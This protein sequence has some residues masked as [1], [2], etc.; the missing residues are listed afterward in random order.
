M[1]DFFSAIFGRTPDS[2]ARS[3]SGIPQ[4]DDTGVA[5]R[6]RA[7]LAAD[8]QRG[9]TT[10]SMHMRTL[11]D[12]CRGRDVDAAI[13]CMRRFAD[14]FRQIGLT[15]SVHLYPY[16]RWALER[17]HTA[18]IQ[19][20]SIYRDMERSTLLI[21][22]ILTDYLNSPWERDRRRR[23]VHVVVRVAG[24]FGHAVRLE[25]SVLLPLYLPPGQ[26]RYVTSTAA[27]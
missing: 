25:T 5:V 14:E 27:S 11:L 19:F 21:E 12:A 2:S 16:L 3:A 23:F 24:L 17:D 10:A 26:Y 22:A 15:R 20:E 6:Y 13:S 4:E 18:T 7:S 8:I 1:P 9:H